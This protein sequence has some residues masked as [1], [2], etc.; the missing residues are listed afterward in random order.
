MARDEDVEPPSASTAASTP[1]EVAP[2]GHVGADGRAA[3]ADGCLVR[4]LGSAQDR[5]RGTGSR[6]RVGDPQA[7]AAAAARDER[8]A[9]RRSKS[10]DGLIVRGGRRRR[11]RPGRPRRRRPGA[12]ELDARE[13]VGTGV[14]HLVDGD[15]PSPSGDAGPDAGSSHEASQ[16]LR[17]TISTAGARRRAAAATSPTRSAL[18]VSKQTRRSPTCSTSRSSS[19]AVRSP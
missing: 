18:A 16:S 13:R 9:S 14:E 3:D 4:S 19:S 17:W 5:D 8:A 15:P 10:P 12:A 7:D 1:S 2:V 11:R 6:E